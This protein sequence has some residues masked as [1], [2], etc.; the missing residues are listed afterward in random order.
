MPFLEIG[1][2]TLKH[3]KT[4]NNTYANLNERMIR[5]H[6]PSLQR[7]FEKKIK[8]VP[9]YIRNIIN[10]EQNRFGIRNKISHGGGERSST[11]HNSFCSY[12]HRNESLDT[13]L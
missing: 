10:P 6:F 11:A 7:N 4:S 8:V 2:N 13:G 12:E 3:K 9:L 1:K 5:K